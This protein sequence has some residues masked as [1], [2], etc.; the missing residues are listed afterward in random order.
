MGAQ[1]ISAGG[2]DV[3]PICRSL[4]AIVASTLRSTALAAVLDRLHAKPGALTAAGPSSQDSDL[5]PYLKHVR[6]PIHGYLSICVPLDDGDDL[7]T[8]LP[9]A[10]SQPCRD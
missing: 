8:R 4:T 1:S 7:S 5:L 6:D 2:A 3:Q 9:V 10:A